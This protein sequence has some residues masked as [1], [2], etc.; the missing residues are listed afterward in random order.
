V[1]A[2]IEQQVVTSEPYVAFFDN[3]TSADL[4]VHLAEVEDEL[5]NGKRCKVS[6]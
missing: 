1:E 5:R 3:S 4:E 6:S 2:L